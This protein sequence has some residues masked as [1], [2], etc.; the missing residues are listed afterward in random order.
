MK[1][2]FE[3]QKEFKMST[4]DIELT[5]AEVVNLVS[6]FNQEIED[7]KE[8]E[9]AFLNSLPNLVLWKLH[10]NVKNLM[11][12]YQEFESMRGSIQ[13]DLQI[14]WFDEEHS[15]QVKGEEEDVLQIKEEYIEAY[16][17]AVAEAN[18]KLNEILIDKTTYKIQTIDMDTEI[19]KNIDKINPKDFEKIDMLMFMNEQ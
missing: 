7:Q 1:Y 3:R 11:S 17:K 19:E 14:K 2:N 4:K 6:F 5:T 18:Q 9:N 15:E 8:N 12:T 10:Q 16:Q 13:N